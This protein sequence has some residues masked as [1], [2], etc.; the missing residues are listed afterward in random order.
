MGCDIHMHFE[1]KENGEWKH[2]DWRKRFQKGTYSDGSPQYD[3]N[4][5]FEHPLYIGRNYNLF[6]IL[7]NV[8]NGRGFAGILTGSGFKPISP[9]RGLPGNVT[10]GVKAESDSWGVDGHSHSW[11]ML[12][13]VLAFDYD[14]Q[15]TTQYGVVSEKE[16]LHFK[17]NGKPDSWAG[18]VSGRSVEH[19]SN[20]EMELILSG[21]IEREEGINYYT[22]VQ[23]TETYKASVG[24]E[25]FNTLNHLRELG[26]PDNVRLVFWFDN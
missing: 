10:P 5:I 20:A 9:P 8:R 21:Q 18:D 1:V 11:L 4:Q 26:N 19:V 13:E 24:N 2:L 25:W 15:G 3:Y 7:A 17:E 22:R 16:Y 23:W 6:A 14:G 12:S